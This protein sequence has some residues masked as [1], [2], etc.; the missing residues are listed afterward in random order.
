MALGSLP[1]WNG[2]IVIDATNP[3]EFLDPS[4]PDARDPGNPLAVWGLKF[5]RLIDGREPPRHTP[6]ASGDPC[7]HDS[8]G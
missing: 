4:S 6:R 5:V 7:E 3:V 1:V 8:L 2:R